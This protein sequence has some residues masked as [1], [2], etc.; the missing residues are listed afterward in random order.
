M[1]KFKRSKSEPETDEQETAPSAAGTETETET[2]AVEAPEDDSPEAVLAQRDE[3]LA[4]WQR[5]QAD[6][7]NLR[8]RS[9]EDVESAVRRTM[10]PLLEGLLIVMD[11]LDMALSAP[12]ESEEAKNLALGVRMTRDQ[13][14]A[15]L[16]REGV[17]AIDEASEFDPALHEAVATVDSPEAEPGSIIET[18]RR[19]YRW[20]GQ[21]LRHAHVK[22]A[23]D[24]SAGEQSDEN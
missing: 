15:S 21:V 3:Y 16:K 17:D 6:F 9:S 5:A 2:A 23:R 10:M 20:R 14:L 1:A 7:Q 11:H 13:F 24:P 4:R 8:R 12:I 19:G 18:V 22:V